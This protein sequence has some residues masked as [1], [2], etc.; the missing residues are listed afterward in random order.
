MTNIQEI[1]SVLLSHGETYHG[2][3][4]DDVAEDWDSYGFIAA[5]VDE[6]CE[7]GVWD[8][9]TA[10]DFCAAG[11]RPCHVKKVSR[12]MIEKNGADAYTSGCPIYAVCNGDLSTRKIVKEWRAMQSE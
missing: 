12:R 11:M 3:R 4:V 7:I 2:G 10:N 6:W 1:A 5:Q 8:A 9:A